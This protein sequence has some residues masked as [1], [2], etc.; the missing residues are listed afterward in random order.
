[1]RTGQKQVVP[2]NIAVRLMEMLWKVMLIFA[3]LFL[4]LIA[5]WSFYSLWLDSLPLKFKII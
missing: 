5:I 4:Y 1:M 3:D 2:K